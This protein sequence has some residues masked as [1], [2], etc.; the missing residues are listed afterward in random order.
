MTFRV[1]KVKLSDRKM[2]DL[3]LAR[4]AFDSVFVELTPFPIWGYHRERALL[5]RLSDCQITHPAPSSGQSVL[6]L[7]QGMAAADVPVRRGRSPFHC[8]ANFAFP[9]DGHSPGY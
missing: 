6:S 5:L 2:D 1:R 3:S 4:A 8:S 9:F 7:A